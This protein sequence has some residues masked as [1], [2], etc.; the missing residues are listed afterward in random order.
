MSDLDAETMHG[1]AAVGLQHVRR[2]G[3]RPE[4][5][6]GIPAPFPAC[7]VRFGCPRS[8]CDVQ[9]VVD[10]YQGPPQCFGAPPH[11]PCFM[12][13]EALVTP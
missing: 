7:H 2:P 1:L 13:P 12:V 4:W 5:R 6:A 8:D 3:L 11:P 9:T 10:V